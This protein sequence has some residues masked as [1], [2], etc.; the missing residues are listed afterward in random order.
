MRNLLSAGI[1]CIETPGQLLCITDSSSLAK[2]IL[3]N[4]QN[5]QNRFLIARNLA[6]GFGVVDTEATVIQIEERTAAG[7]LRLHLLT[8]GGGKIRI[9][10]TQFVRLVQVGKDSLELLACG[11]EHIPVQIKIEIHAYLFIARSE[12]VTGS[13]EQLDRTLSSGPRYGVRIDFLQCCKYLQQ[14]IEC[15]GGLEIVFLQKI[16]SNHRSK[17]V[18]R[19]FALDDREY[20][21]LTIDQIL[22]HFRILLPE[23]VEIGHI[24]LIHILHQRLEDSRGSIGRHIF[25]LDISDIRPVVGGKENVLLV[26]I[27]G[28][29]NNL[30]VELEIGLLKNRLLGRSIILDGLH[31]SITHQHLDRGRSTCQFPLRVRERNFCCRSFLRSFC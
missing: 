11:S 13:F 25:G 8:G 31:C 7:Q 30:I 22:L 1:H 27:A 20:I 17:T 23:L 28:E 21:Q 29:G 26:I 2:T 14:L 24:L 19:F 16:G 18:C 9:K 6:K 10:H 4:R 5:L 3:R 12:H 15:R